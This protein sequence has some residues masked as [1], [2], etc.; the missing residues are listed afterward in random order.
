MQL[1]EY[2]NQLCLK[3]M[4]ILTRLLFKSIDFLD[5]PLR[6]KKYLHRS[7]PKPLF[8]RIW[9]SL[10]LVPTCIFK[11]KNRTEKQK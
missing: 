6:T 9:F 4:L 1:Q 3:Y 8:M 7:T 2:K 10:N 11:C 5:A